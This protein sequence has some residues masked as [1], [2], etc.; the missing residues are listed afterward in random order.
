LAEEDFP[1]EAAVSEAA[2]A[3]VSVSLDAI[4]QTAG[5]AWTIFLYF[6]NQG[7]SFL[8]TLI[9]VYPFYRFLFQ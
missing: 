7:L 5:V 4:W 9:F 3:V 6:E 2:E 8:Q 1:A